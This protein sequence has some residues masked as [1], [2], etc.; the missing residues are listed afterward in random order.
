MGD[1]HALEVG[2]ED[3]GDDLAEVAVVGVALD[4][5]H[6]HVAAEDV[7]VP[8]DGRV[9]VGNRDAHVI[10][11]PHRP[12][13]R[14]RWAALAFGHVLPLDTFPPPWPADPIEGRGAAQASA[15][16]QDSLGSGRGLTGG[17]P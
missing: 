11:R 13:R 17:P 7:A 14:R 10:E 16:R 5:L 15:A 3:V 8:G 4:G 1:L 6:Q 12:L 9:D 2:A